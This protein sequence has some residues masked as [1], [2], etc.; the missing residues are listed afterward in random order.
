M[1]NLSVHGVEFTTDELRDDIRGA[2]DKGLANRWAFTPETVEALLDDADVMERENAALKRT[3]EDLAHALRRVNRDLS[4]G[5]ELNPEVSATLVRRALDKHG[6]LRDVDKPEELPA[7]WKRI[8]DAVEGGPAPFSD[9]CP[10]CGA[11]AYQECKSSC[12]DRR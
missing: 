4:M 10:A 3:V 7:A 5:A 11:V 1:R 8:A 12:E 9:A 2:R 6:L